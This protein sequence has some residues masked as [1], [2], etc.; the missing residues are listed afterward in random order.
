MRPRIMRRWRAAALGIAGAAL[1]LGACTQK[2]APVELNQPAQQPQAEAP[3]PVSDGT[4]AKMR[5]VAAP[6]PEV[7]VSTLSESPLP[8]PGTAAAAAADAPAFRPLRKPRTVR[9]RAIAAAPFVVIVG[10][11]DTV[12]AIARRH[13]S[14]PRA[15]IELNGLA[16]PYQLQI[17]QRLRL[18]SAR[19]H[20]VADGETLYGISRRYGVAMNQLVRAN[21]IPAP[22]RVQAGTR[23]RV[24]AQTT[25]PRRDAAPAPVETV[26]ADAR[27]LPPSPPPRSGQPFL[28]PVDGE[29]ISR[30]GPKP[31]GLH[32][33]GINI[34]VPLGTPVRAAEDGVVAY[35]GNELRGYGNLVLIRHADGWMTAYA[36]NETLLVDR[37]DLVRRGQTISHAGRSGRV[38]RPQA[39]FEIRRNGDP[40]D[41]LTLLARN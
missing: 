3:P 12:Y 15:I 28:W 39:H 41:P 21:D 34:A 24:P 17:G 36:H 38:S 23:L 30:F 7:S 19:F 31:G 22:Y 26:R 5:V 9:S 14:S 6:P 37:G 16:A 29:I 20:E 2:P 1:L 27:V 32:N 18:P 25:G 10:S 4:R 35:A 40:R 8:A 11:G 13:D 33:D